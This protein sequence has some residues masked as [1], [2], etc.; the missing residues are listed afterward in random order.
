MWL[1][2]ASKDWKNTAQARRAC[3]SSAERS[4]AITVSRRPLPSSLGTVAALS[5]V[6]CW[7]ANEALFATVS[8]PDDVLLSD[9]L[10]HASIIDGCRLA[11]RNTAKEVYRHSDL[12]DL[13]QKLR[14][15]E[16][17]QVRWVITDGVFSMEGDVAHLAE[18]VTICRQHHAMLVVDD[19]HG[20]GVLGDRGRGTPEFAGVFGE[21]DIL[22]G[23]LGKALGGGAGGYVAASRRVIELLQQRGRPS[24]FSNAL[25]ATVACSA[26]AAVENPTNPTGTCL[27]V[28]RECWQGAARAGQTRLS[29]SRLADSD[30]SDH[31]RRR[32][33]GAPPGSA[34]LG[35]RRPCCRLRVSCCS[36]RRGPPS[37]SNFRRPDRRPRRTSPRRLRKAL[38]AAVD[39]SVG[40]MVT[41]YRNEKTV[42]RIT[43]DG[44]SSS[45]R[46]QKTTLVVYARR[47][48]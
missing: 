32:S 12:E 48:R 22:T 45:I 26:L 2:P 30:H 41:M 38:N 33:R 21:V 3:G 34:T 5:Y 14:K 35:T 37:R 31:D 28:A 11:H 39:D 27:H 25:P 29:V 43:P 4:I 16:D 15:H 9:E 42:G 36:S 47:P 10:N 7:N 8:T 46:I 1:P 44:R 24:L 13:K 40:D 18:L 23:T 17:K 20:V 19:S 6:S